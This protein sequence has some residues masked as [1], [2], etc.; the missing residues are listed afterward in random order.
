MFDKEAYWKNRNQGFRGQGPHPYQ[1]MRQF[2]AEMFEK[3]KPKKKKKVK[4]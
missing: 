1:I 3:M 2:R 4:A